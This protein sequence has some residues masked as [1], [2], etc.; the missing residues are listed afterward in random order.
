MSNSA[1]NIG[2]R[3]VANVIWEIPVGINRRFLS[4]GNRLVDTLVGGWNANSIVTAQTGLPFS[5]SAPDK[6]FTGPDHLSRPNCVGNAYA[7]AT[8]NTAELTSNSTTAFYMNPAAFSI[9]SLHV[10]KLPAEKLDRTGFQNVD[11]SLFKVIPIHEQRRVEIRAE[12]FNFFNHPNFGFPIST[13]G[14]ASF[15][16]I[17]STSTPQRNI[18]LAA[19]IYF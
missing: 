11:F 3:F 13:L 15:G 17:T 2:Q 7:G 6:S 5:V 10:R 19:K 16:H 18:Q 8:R 9:P 14:S 1:F 12:F 4:H